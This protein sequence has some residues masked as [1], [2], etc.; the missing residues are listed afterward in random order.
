MNNKANYKKGYKNEIIQLIYIC[1]MIPY[2]AL[3]LL[4]N[5]PRLYQ[6]AIKEMEKEGILTVDKKGGEKN[7]RLQD[8]RNNKMKYEPYIPLEYIRYYENT[9][10]EVL[11]RLGEEDYMAAKREMRNSSTK[12]MMYASGVE[13]TPDK[14]NLQNEMIKAEDVCYYNSPELKSIIGYENEIEIVIERMGERSSKL[15]NTRINGLLV[16]PG[17]NYAVYNIGKEMIEWKRKGEMK[18]A[19]SISNLIRKKSEEEHSITNQKE[20]IVIAQTPNQYVRIINNTNE[21]RAGKMNLINIDYTYDKMYAIP[22]DRNGVLM[23]KIMTQRGWR[24]KILDSILSEEIQ[25]ASERSNIDC[26]GY[27]E[28]KEIHQLVFCIPDMAKLKNYIRRAQ[29]EDDKNKFRIY[30]FTHQLPIIATLAGEYVQVSKV[31]IDKYYMRYFV[32]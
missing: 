26:D 4:A 18:I 14:R 21:K 12:I 8:R 1:G 30:C 10:R 9:S 15:N 3:R 5:E 32:K 27:D 22:E 6:R 25:K 11:K 31:D 19:A 24:K 2:R 23:M 29:I 20:A 13:I 16:S 17:G 7:L 28:K